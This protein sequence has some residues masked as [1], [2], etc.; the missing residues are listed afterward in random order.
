MEEI[1]RQVSLAQ[2]RLNLERFLGVL[3]WSLFGCLLVAVIGLTV[4]KIWE[5]PVDANVWFASWLGG[6]VALGFLIAAAWTYYVRRTPVEAAIE[7]DRRFGLKERVSSSLSLSPAEL[8][9]EAGQALLHDATQRVETLDVKE[10]FQVAPTR[11]TALP[12]IPAIAVLVLAFLPNFV[13]NASTTA[14]TTTI[15]IDAAVKDANKELKKALVKKAEEAEAKGLKDAEALFKQLQEAVDD[16]IKSKDPADQKKAMIKLNDLSKELQKRRDQLG[17]AEKVKEQLDKL[18]DIEQGPADRAIKSMQE[19]NFD[20]AQE[21]MKKLQEKL[22]KGEL[23]KEEKEQ[24]AKQ[25]EQM[26]KKVQEMA[27]KHEQAKQDLAEQIKAAEK[28][29]DREK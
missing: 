28:Q 26:Q 7:L 6:S 15:A 11:R 18:K 27:Q 8:A 12:L 17:G 2:W 23:T 5:L 10:R 3:A 16:Q 20:K 21:E 29:G 4:P 19:G 25:L 9:S 1:K 22:A 13:N 24:L 14:A